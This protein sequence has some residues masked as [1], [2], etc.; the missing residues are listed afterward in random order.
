MTDGVM[1]WVA[2]LRLSGRT[3]DVGS[4]DVNGC[5]RSLFD[6]YL[7]L[8]MRPGP[9]VDIVADAHALPFLDRSF[10][11]VLC[12][13]MLEHDAAFWLTL[14]ELARVTK[15][16]GVVA[17]TARGNGFPK[18][19]YPSDYWRFTT[20]AMTV[21]LGQVAGLDVLS[22]IDAPGERAVFGHGQRPRT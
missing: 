6:D 5:V 21:L 14:P 22:A 19:D 13:E 7:G 9:N 11:T 2:S 4:F 1:V 10:D 20:D 18:H 17:V 3:P 12:L 15:P 16:G 8:D